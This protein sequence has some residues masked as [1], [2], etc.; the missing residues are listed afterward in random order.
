MRRHGGGALV[1]D[2]RDPVVTG[3]PRDGVDH[4]AVVRAG[5]EVD[6]VGPGVGHGGALEQEV[7]RPVDED[8]GG[9]RARDRDVAQ[10]DAAVS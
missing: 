1:G 5:G 10:R 9:R 2:H 7:L 6:P 4:P 3:A 8:P